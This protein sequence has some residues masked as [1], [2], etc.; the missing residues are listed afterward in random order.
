MNL[1]K[2]AAIAGLLAGL[3]LPNYTVYAQS[4]VLSLSDAIRLVFDQ[5]PQLRVYQLRREALE[6]EVRT[7]E[8][9]PATVVNAE[10]EN[11]AGTGDLNWFQGTEWSLS[12]SRVIEMGNKPQ[13]RGNVVRRRQAMV[14]AERQIVELDL[15][16]QTASAYIE[17][18]VA[19]ARQEVLSRSLDLAT[20]TLAE[21]QSRVDA[22][23]THD[24]ERARAEAAVSQ[25]ELTLQSAA[26]TINA[27]RLRL[28]AFW[29]EFSPSEFQS[30]ADLFR[31]EALPSVDELLERLLMS[32]AISAF[33]SE[34]R[35]REAELA[36]ARA[37][38][39]NDFSVGIGVRHL[40]EL[41]DTAFVA[42]FSMPLQ[43]S[44]RAQ[45]AITA[46]QA[47]LLRVEA[48]EQSAIWQMSGQLLALNQQRRSAIARHDVLQSE[49]IPLLQAALDSTL[50]A[51]E[52][53][54]F[55]FTEI[56]TAQR[57]LIEAELTRIDAAAQAHQLRIEIERLSGQSFITDATSDGGVQ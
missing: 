12:L 48:S 1:L 4:N 43:A 32:P 3:C 24:S 2:V 5:N 44:Q 6:G 10:A 54:L 11:V 41:N 52:T 15:L 56:S 19:I 45:G 30:A 20:T 42:Q 26:Y 33:T 37:Q 7:A 46:A 8:L 16:S 39:Y 57:A 21:I 29:G 9:S 51:Y 31:L 18:T 36:L 28:S 53:G 17:L 47:N 23:R 38:Q 34:S 14:D 55:D 25:A 40:A 35:L 22:G 13:A 50:T 27:A 49:V